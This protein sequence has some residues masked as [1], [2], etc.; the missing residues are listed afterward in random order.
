MRQNPSGRASIPSSPQAAATAEAVYSALFCGAGLLVQKKYV[1]GILY[2]LVEIA[3]VL[4]F[5]RQMKAQ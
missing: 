1:K 2:A 3:A 5:L 4:L